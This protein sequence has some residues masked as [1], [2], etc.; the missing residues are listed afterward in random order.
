MKKNN[1]GYLLEVDIEYPKHLH[2]A[3]EDL[4]FLC[5]KRKN[6]INHL[7]MK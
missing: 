5:E 1:K 3:H 6:Q 2:K 7:N 4:P